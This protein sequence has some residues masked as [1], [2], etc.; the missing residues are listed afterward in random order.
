[1]LYNDFCSFYREV[2][3]PLKV[4]NP[5]RK[6]LDGQSA[7]GSRDSAGEFIFGDRTWTVHTD[8]HLEPLQIAF[9]GFEEGINPFVVR[10]TSRGFA[11]TLSRELRAK[12]STGFKH[13]YIYSW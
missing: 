6:R 3:A 4:T 1:M 12:Q 13:M 7:G 8:T 2:V 10:E 9:D 5:A 11:L